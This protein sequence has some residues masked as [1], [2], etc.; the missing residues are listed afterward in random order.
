MGIAGHIRPDGDC[1]GTCMALY[2]YIKLYYPEIDVRVYLENPR[3]VFSHIDRMDEIITEPDGSR[4]FDLFV[5]C[6]VS[7]LNRLAVAGEYF[8]TA[9]R[10][11]CIDHH[12]SNTG[13]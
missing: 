5:T 10:T 3:P 4:I 6:D 9:K 1:V 11:A 7:A 2:L 13:A 8:E 12:V